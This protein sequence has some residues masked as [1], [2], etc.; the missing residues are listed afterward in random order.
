MIQAVWA[1]AAPISDGYESLDSEAQSLLIEEPSLDHT[2][3]FYSPQLRSIIF[4]RIRSVFE[5]LNLL[6]RSEF[7]RM[8]LYY[9]YYKVLIIPWQSDACESSR[10]RI[11]VLKHVCI[12][13]S[14]VEV[15]DAITRKG[16]EV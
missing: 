5:R 16:E 7:P 1:C 15:K 13:T 11:L 14:D 2:E 3:S 8:S 4:I 10:P 6:S 12:L 9:F